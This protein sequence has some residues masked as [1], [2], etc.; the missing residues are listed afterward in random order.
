MDESEAKDL[1][2]NS[3]DKIDVLDEEILNLI[4]ERTSLAKDIV[5]SKKALNLPIFDSSRENIIYTKISNLARDKGLDTEKTVEIF[6]LL[7]QMSKD[8]QKKYI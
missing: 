4:V 8:E 5:L 7:A 1:L 2:N 3:R 6:K